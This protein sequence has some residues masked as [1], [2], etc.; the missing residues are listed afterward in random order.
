MLQRVRLQGR[1]QDGPRLLRVHGAAPGREGDA[2]RMDCVMGRARGFKR[3]LTLHSSKWES[4]LM[5]LLE[6]HSR[7]FVVGALDFVESVVGLEGFRCLFGRR[8]HR[9][10]S[11]LDGRSPFAM[12]SRKVP[13][14]LLA[15]L[16]DRWRQTSCSVPVWRR[17]Q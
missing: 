10:R 16:G 5:V 8:P 14:A 9:P 1:G 3:I 17:I 4:R 2:V 6:E 12:A 13:K 15:E 7:R 11:S